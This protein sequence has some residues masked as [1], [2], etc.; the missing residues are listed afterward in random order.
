MPITG[1]ANEEINRGSHLSRVLAA[2]PPELCAE[3]I[4]HATSVEVRL[5]GHLLTEPFIVNE[6]VA[7]IADAL[8]KSEVQVYAGHSRDKLLMSR[9]LQLVFDLRPHPSAFPR[10]MSRFRVHHD[11]P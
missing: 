3:V 9:Q 4:Y 1:A 7:K 2:L 5:A 11:D 10:A 6:T 8:D